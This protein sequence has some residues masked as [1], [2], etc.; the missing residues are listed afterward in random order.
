MLETRT[1]EAYVPEAFGKYENL[2]AEG[3]AQLSAINSI[4]VDPS[5]TFKP[6]K[7]SLWAHAVRAHGAGACDQL[8]QPI[9]PNKQ[10]LRA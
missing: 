10:G 8:M 3:H 5:V 1:S 2:A 4:G 9:L 7:P 6:K